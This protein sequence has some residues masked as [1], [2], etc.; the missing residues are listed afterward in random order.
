MK[1]SLKESVD[2]VQ[3]KLILFAPVVDREVQRSLVDNVCKENLV[4]LVPTVS[5]LKGSWLSGRLESRMEG[6]I[7]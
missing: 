7:V 1:S 5:R 6:S 3:E 2:K 4:W